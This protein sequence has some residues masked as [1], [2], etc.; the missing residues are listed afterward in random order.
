MKLYIKVESSSQWIIYN[1]IAK[2]YT[3]Y[4]S[5][6]K[7]I[8]ILLKKFNILRKNKEYLIG[9]TRKLI[10][11]TYNNYLRGSFFIVPKFYK[12]ILEKD[13]IQNVNKTQLDLKMYT[14]KV[15]LSAILFQNFKK[16]F[17]QNPIVKKF[18][19]DEPDEKPYS[20]KNKYYIFNLIFISSNITLPETLLF[21]DEFTLNLI[22]NNFILD[23]KSLSNSK[24]LNFKRSFVFLFQFLN[25]K[26][27]IV[28]KRL[29]LIC[30]ELLQNK[31]V[32]FF[33][34]NTNTFSQKIFLYTLIIS[35]Q[36][37]QN[38]ANFNICFNFKIKQL[39]TLFLFF[40]DSFNFNRI[41]NYRLFIFNK[42][43]NSLMQIGILKTLSVFKFN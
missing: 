42:I 41:K 6:K 12:Y 18:E 13:I 7:K 34:I 11:F 4:P 10:H 39:W 37:I 16:Y 26:G 33:I 8:F 27:R 3:K 29:D 19:S 24:R 21:T 40:N 22:K 43:K 36:K 20:I 38:L 17:L 9:I 25:L 35:I 31:N 2:K 30:T 1:R 5:K 14:M 32:F 28:F 23:C 15:R